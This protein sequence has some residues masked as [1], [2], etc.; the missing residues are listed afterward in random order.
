M[1]D[2]LKPA[3]DL[4][5]EA[6]GKDGPEGLR[7]VV[8][9]VGEVVAIN[10]ASETLTLGPLEEVLPEMGRFLGV[11]WVDYLRDD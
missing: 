2:A 3:M 10:R 1:T 6:F 11:A 9:Q 8:N 4:I 7:L 5:H